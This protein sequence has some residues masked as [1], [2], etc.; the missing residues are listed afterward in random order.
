VRLK[1]KHQIA[2]ALWVFYLCSTWQWSKPAGCTHF[3]AKLGMYGVHD[4]V[5]VWETSWMDSF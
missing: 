5:T 2:L 4:F 3:N 1:K